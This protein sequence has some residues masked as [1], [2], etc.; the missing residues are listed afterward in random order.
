MKVLQLGKFYPILGGVEKVMWE[1]TEGLGRAGVDCD[2]L[3]A[4]EKPQVIQMG[5]HSRCICVKS[6]FKASATMISPAMISY[7]H[8]HCPEYDIIHVHHPDPMAALALRLSGYKGKVV[9][10]WHSDIVKQRFLLKFYL[11]LQSW[12]VRR[13][14]KIVGT[15]PV[16]V[17]ESPFL[18]RV[19]DKLTYMPIGVDPLPNACAEPSEYK[20]VFSLGR[21]VGYKGYRF[22]IDA[23]KYL[24]DNY[25][26]V[27]GGEGPLREE[28]EAQIKAE[29]LESKVSLP[30]RIP[31]EKLPQMFAQCSVFCLS[32]I[33]KTEAF[34]IVQIEAMSIGKPVVATRI[35]GSGVSWV[36]EHGYSGLNAEPCSGPLLAK[37]ILEVTEDPEVYKRYCNNALERYKALF[38]KE[39]MIENCLEI[40]D[41]L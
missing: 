28:L 14:D 2:M 39:A 1:L 11:P 20:I 12:I 29:G 19:Q 7:L 35:P 37:A 23:A 38:T 22:L 32:S 8:K 30:G 4:C 13:S 6:L 25:R 36:N 24:P 5:E 17:S 26:V 40:Y 21:L 16:Y 15:S 34:G 18:Q 33:W 3:C 31:Q 41:K 9:L 10:H 27:I